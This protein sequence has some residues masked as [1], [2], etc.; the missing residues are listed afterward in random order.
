MA[1]NINIGGLKNFT[2]YPKHV[3]K[4]WTILDKSSKC[5]IPYDLNCG[6]S[7]P[8]EDTS[9]DNYY[10]SHTLEHVLPDRLPFLLSEIRRTLKVNGKFRVV[11]PDIQKGIQMYVDN[12]IMLYSTKAPALSK[13]YVPTTLGYLLSWINSADRKH[14]DGHA[15]AFD[16]ETMYWYLDQAR[17]REITFM[18]YNI[19][20]KVFDGCDFK[21]Y[22]PFSLY[23]EAIR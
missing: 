10:C 14:S 19:C 9:V 13:Q 11:V 18:Q 16:Y 22:E 20:S 1:L 15:N 7:M 23:V 3:Q 5:D 6:W 8:I 12:D 17:F 2:R 4:Q 21:R